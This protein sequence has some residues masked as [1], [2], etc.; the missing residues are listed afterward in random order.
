MK[1]THMK[2]TGLKRA[3]DLESI[4]VSSAVKLDLLLRGMRSPRRLNIWS[5]GRVPRGW[6][7]REVKWRMDLPHPEAEAARAVK[8]LAADARKL[9]IRTFVPADFRLPIVQICGRS[10]SA[11]VVLATLQGPV[12]RMDYVG[13]ALKKQREERKGRGA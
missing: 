6:K 8:T 10:W 4:L 7:W 1:M 13:K 9:R 2:R 3:V 12:A 5:E 11:G